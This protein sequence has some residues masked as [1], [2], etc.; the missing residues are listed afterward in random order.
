MTPEEEINTGTS[1]KKATETVSMDPEKFLSGSSMYILTGCIGLFVLFF[2][3]YVIVSVYKKIIHVRTSRS[4]IVQQLQKDDLN[5]TALHT[6]LEIQPHVAHFNQH[7]NSVS[8]FSP[9]FDDDINYEEI[10]IYNSADESSILESYQLP[11]EFNNDLNPHTHLSHA[12]D[13]YLTPVADAY[14][15]PVDDAYSTPVKDVYLTP[16]EDVYLTPVKDAHVSLVEDAR[17]VYIDVIE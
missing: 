4:H 15:T 12:D 10:D 3:I 2:C 14:L 13:S 11:S 8:Y 6:R 1:S 7:R 9:V 17:H 5:Y 16:V